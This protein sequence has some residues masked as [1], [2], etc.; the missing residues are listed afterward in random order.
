MTVLSL[1]NSV[2][3]VKSQFLPGYAGWWLEGTIRSG[4]I[5]QP[6]CIIESEPALRLRIKRTNK[7]PMAEQARYR[8]I[9][10]HMNPEISREYCLNVS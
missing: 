7:R 6:I 3:R 5:Y 9:L 10:A 4:L 1:V 8:H 2:L